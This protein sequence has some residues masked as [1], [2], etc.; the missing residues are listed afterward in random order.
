[1]NRVRHATLSGVVHHPPIR[2]DRL[3]QPY[4]PSLAV[5]EAL[6]DGRD[7]LGGEPAADQL[8]LELAQFVGVPQS[9]LL[10]ANGLDELLNAIYLWRRDRGTL[11]LFPPSDPTAERRAYVH[12]VPVTPVRRNAIFGIQLDLETAS[13]LPP[14]CWAVVQ[15]PND[16]TG[17]LLEPLDAVRLARA[18]EVLVIDERHGAYA[19]RSM[20]PLVREFENI[21]LLQTLETWAALHSFPVAFAV[22]PPALLA[23]LNAFRVRDDLSAGATMAALATLGDLASVQSAVRRVRQE[24][25]RL[26]R[27]L[28]KLNMV[29]PCP[30]WGNFLP[31]RVERGSAA[32]IVT[33]LADRGIRVHKPLQP[34]LARLL[35]VSARLPEQTDALKQALIEVGREL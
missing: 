14:G 16:P 26:Y 23:E 12:R 35:R 4:G 15:S 11:V 28:R 21:I 3:D 5:L 1:M 25:S 20:L 24:R 18:C 7:W 34:E 33:G 6:S 32:Q 13:D 9:W 31:V 17:T 10:V 19:G 30:S 8:R 2:L 22:A 29:S 27:M